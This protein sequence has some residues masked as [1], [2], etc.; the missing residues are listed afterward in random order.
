MSIQSWLS[1]F[2]ILP[3]KFLILIWMIFYDFLD[4]FIIIQAGTN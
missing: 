1:H 3:V 4:F 2:H